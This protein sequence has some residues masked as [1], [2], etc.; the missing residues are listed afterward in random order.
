MDIKSIR[1]LVTIADQRSFQ[2]AA[3]ALGMSV[4]NVSLQ[5]QGLESHFGAQLFDRSSRPPQLTELGAELVTR[6]RDLLADWE[7]LC[8]SSIQNQTQGAL[9]VGAVHTAVAGGVSVA[10]GRLRKRDPGLFIQL[11]TALTPELIRQLENQSIDCAIVTEPVNPVLDMRFEKIAKEELGVIAHKKA[12][13]DSYRE[14]LQK[15]PYLRFNR[16]ATLAQLVDAELKRRDIAVHSTME[17]TTLDAIESL[18]KN[19]LGVSVVPI[20]K[21]VRSLPRGIR[22]LPFVSPP[23]Y[24]NL[25]LLVKE[26]CPRMHLVQ[27]LLEELYRT[28]SSD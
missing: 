27:I 25:G 21:H 15:N 28:Y 18:V 1:T 22:T 9:K 24:R 13:G 10:L 11:H 3:K 2:A 7:T 16:H 20:G 19:G 17:I 23:L 12:E 6:G 14:V 8:N 26:N 4:S 5:I